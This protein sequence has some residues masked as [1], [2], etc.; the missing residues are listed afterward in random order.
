MIIMGAGISDLK[1][2]LSLEMKD[3]LVLSSV[4]RASDAYSLS[5]AKK[6]F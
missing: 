2:F 4:L 3:L 6:G 5:Q 1:Q